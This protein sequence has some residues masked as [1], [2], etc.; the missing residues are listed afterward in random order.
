MELA[1][2][3]MPTQLYKMAD[4]NSTTSTSSFGNWRNIN[5]EVIYLEVKK[6][7]DHDFEGM[8]EQR[9]HTNI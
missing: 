8:L 9:I 3:N 6:M 4:K 1:A 2:K 7:L 5:V